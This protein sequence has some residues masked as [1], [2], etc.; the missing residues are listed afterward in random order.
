MEITRLGSGAYKISLHREELTQKGLSYETLDYR[1]R[2]TLSFLSE[3]LGEAQMRFQSGNFVLPA[4]LENA[5]VEIFPDGHG[6]CF[7]YFSL[8]HTTCRRKAGIT[9]DPPVYC[10]YISQPRSL[11][12]LLQQLIEAPQAL[13]CFCRTYALDDGFL[14]CVS[15]EKQRETG[16]KALL[17]EFSV[18]ISFEKTDY[19]RLAEYANECKESIL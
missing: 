16:L 9:E 19:L 3:M 13:C 17:N 4:S 2:Q 15:P 18:P 1:S 10:G 11:K 6:G 5:Y 8:E 7:L 12:L 14:L